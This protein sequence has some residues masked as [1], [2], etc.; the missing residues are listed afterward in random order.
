MQ[1][2]GDP[3][4]I[5]FIIYINMGST[6]DDDSSGCGEVKFSVVAAC[7]PLDVP[8]VRIIPVT[9]DILELDIWWSIGGEKDGSAPDVTLNISQHYLVPF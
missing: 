9:D 1:G 7:L 8:Q 5:P 6:T 2:E 4:H 3:I